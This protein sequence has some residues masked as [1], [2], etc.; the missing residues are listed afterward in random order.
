MKVALV[1]DWLVTYRGGEKVLEQLAGM[2][3]AAPIYTLFYDPR[4]LPPSLTQREIIFPKNLNRFVGFRKE[5]LLA[6]YPTIIESF[7]LTAYDLIISSSSCVAKGVI[8]GPHAKH[9]CYMH[10]PMRYIWDQQKFYFSTYGKIPGLSFIANLLAT[11]L[12]MWDVT[13][14]NRVDRFVANSHF[15]AQRIARYYRRDSVVIAPPV[16]LPTQPP[17]WKKKDYYLIAGAWVPYKRLE[18]AVEACKKMDKNLIVAGFGSQE[19]KLRAAAGPRTQ[20]I[21]A[22]DDATLGRL[23]GEARALLFPGIEDFGILPIEAMAQGTPVIAMAK[24]GALDYVTSRKTGVFFEEQTVESLQNAIRVFES[25][26]FDPQV[27]YLASQQF[28][29]DIFVHRIKKEIET[30]LA[31]DTHAF[32]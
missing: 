18:L 2:F 25:L 14:S 15:V 11:H 27:L 4:K 32:S 29:S 31:R 10:A 8:V 12:R 28:G 24:G 26:Q 6:F 23:L 7:D 1:H 16:Q 20:F 13:S 3:P 9:L 17:Q 30:L 22:P 19:K 5:F 21:Q